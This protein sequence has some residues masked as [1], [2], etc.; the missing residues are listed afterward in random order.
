ML[1]SVPTQQAGI[2][3]LKQ[4]LSTA[5]ATNSA[6]LNYL[7]VT[8]LKLQASSSL[9]GLPEPVSNLNAVGDTFPHLYIG[10]RPSSKDFCLYCNTCTTTNLCL[11]KKTRR[12]PF[13]NPRGA[14]GVLNVYVGLIDR[15][16]LSRR[17]FARPYHFGRREKEFQS[18]AT[19]T[20]E[21][22]VRPLHPPSSPVRNFRPILAPRVENKL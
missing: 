14:M 7:P 12:E 17:P 6:Y 18:M 2:N 16:T 19:H 10:V 20:T 9:L 8:Q 13:F 5:K 11:T 22:Y 1:R 21:H 4:E 15:F 3:I